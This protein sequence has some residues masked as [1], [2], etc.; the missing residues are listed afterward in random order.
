MSFYSTLATTVPQGL[1]CKV[2]IAVVFDGSFAVPYLCEECLYVEKELID[3]WK[4]SADET[5]VL[6]E[7][8]QYT[9]A[10]IAGGFKYSNNSEV[11]DELR[12][13]CSMFNKGLGSIANS[14]KR[15]GENLADRRPNLKLVTLFITFSSDIEDVTDAVPFAKKLQ[16]NGDV[17]IVIGVGSKV[18]QSVLADMSSNVVMSDNLDLALANKVNSMI[19]ELQGAPTAAPVAVTSMDGH[20]IPLVRTIKELEGIKD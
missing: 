11:I 14:V 19:C 8:S 12:R 18:N 3:R 6:L 4:I 16:T 1:P 17:L 15:L 13:R 2:D 20:S 5:E 7:I 10:I 9:P